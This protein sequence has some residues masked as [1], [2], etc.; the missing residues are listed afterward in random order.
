MLAAG[1]ITTPGDDTHPDRIHHPDL[2][3]RKYAE[4]S[5]VQRNADMQRASCAVELAL[6]PGEQAERA[7]ELWLQDEWNIEVLDDRVD[8]H[9]GSGQTPEEAVDAG[10]R[11]CRVQRWIVDGKD[12]TCTRRSRRD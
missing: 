12:A 9:E 7:K 8:A 5:D 11:G 3:S 1:L 6:C 10:E 2:E 4:A